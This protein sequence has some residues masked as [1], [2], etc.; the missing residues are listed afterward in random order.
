MDTEKE[1]K[2]RIA[3]LQAEIEKL[4]AELHEKNIVLVSAINLIALMYPLTQLGGKLPRKLKEVCDE[5]TNLARLVVDWYTAPEDSGFSEE[6][7][8]LQNEAKRLSET[9]ESSWLP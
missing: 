3:A 4:D 1:L 7:L 8:A 5:Y 2:E 6:T 9:P